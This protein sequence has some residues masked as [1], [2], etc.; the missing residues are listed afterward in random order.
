MNLAGIIIKDMEFTV[1]NISFKIDC[2]TFNSLFKGKTKLTMGI[3]DYVPRNNYIAVFID[4]LINNLQDGSMD[5]VAGIF[6][7]QIMPEDE[8]IFLLCVYK[9]MNRFCKHSGQMKSSI[10][11]LK[12]HVMCRIKEIV[13]IM[14]KAFELCYFG[15]AHIPAKKFDEYGNEYLAAIRWLLKSTGLSYHMAP[16]DECRGEEIAVVYSCYSTR[17]FKKSMNAYK[18]IQAQVEKYKVFFMHKESREIIFRFHQD[19]IFNIVLE[20]GFAE[21]IDAIS[22]CAIMKNAHRCYLTSSAE[23][24]GLALKLRAVFMFYNPEITAHGIYETFIRGLQK[25]M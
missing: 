1:N 20:K 8:L 14:H 17:N 12:V 2:N 9:F 13:N 25:N 19:M 4:V 10:I 16:E 22:V 6:M 21:S 23:I 3:D 5:Y 18:I 11:G 15:P 24:E 7:E